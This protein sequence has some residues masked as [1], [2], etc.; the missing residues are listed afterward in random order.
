MASM[1]T[2]RR[3]AGASIAALLL[4]G[5]L[6]IIAVRASS[7]PQLPP[8]APSALIAS[9]IG[10]E[11]RAQPLSGR[12]TVTLDL[13]LPSG[14]AASSSS[15]PLSWITGDH[16]LR[17]WRSPDGMRV[18]E[19]L[20]A[21]EKA[22]VAGATGVWGWDSESFTAVRVALPDEAWSAERRW[23]AAL[24]G[25]PIA[26]ARAALEAVTPS[27]EVRTARPETV[28][29]RA[30]YVL[31]IDPRS[32]GTLVGRIEVAFDSE[33]RVPLRFEVFARGAAR[34]ALSATFDSVSFGHLT[35]AACAG[36]SPPLR[37]RAPTRSRSS[38]GGGRP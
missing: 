36:G 2:G 8:V 34:P 13:G 35:T 15:D 22:I 12:A 14:V 38:D 19:S 17:V 33:H 21:A 20:P 28:A 6:G 16:H 32:D 25:D 30:A 31:V 5:T 9:A 24:L 4:A 37:P 3:V 10:A 29:G 23:P 18:S 26:L 11:A 1:S 27:T 7:A